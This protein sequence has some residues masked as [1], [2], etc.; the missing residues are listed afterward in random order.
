MSRKHKGVQLL[1]MADK[2]VC[3]AMLIIMDGHYDMKH[4]GANFSTTFDGFIVLMS[5]SDT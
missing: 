3:F 2:N 5:H 4:N 1:G